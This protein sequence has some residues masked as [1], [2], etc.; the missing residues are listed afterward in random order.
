MSRGVSRDSRVRGTFPGESGVDIGGDREQE[1]D[2]GEYL[3]RE[4]GY[5]LGMWVDRV[6]GW[7]LFSVDDDGDE[8]D[9]Y[10]RELY[11][12][13]SSHRRQPLS[14]SLQPL[15]PPKKSADRPSIHEYEDGLWGDPTWVFSLAT[16]I[17]F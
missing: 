1:P 13:G 6:I 11:G 8:D 14:Q 5:G 16:Q 3:Y 15:Q 12:E 17:F 2:D 9:M 4:K 7:S 10:R